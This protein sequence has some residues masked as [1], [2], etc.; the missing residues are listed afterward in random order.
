[1]QIFDATPLLPEHHNQWQQIQQ[2]ILKKRLSQ[3]LLLIG[4]TD[5]SLPQFVKKLISLSFCVANT[6]EPCMKCHHCRMIHKAEHPDVHWIKPDKP[7]NGLKIEQIRQLQGLAYQTPQC[8]ASQFFVLEAAE[9]M[10]PSVANALLKILEEPSEHSF[11][12]LVAEHLSS[13]LPTVISRCHILRFHKNIKNNELLQLA[14]HLFAL[15]SEP[16]SSLIVSVLDDLIELLIGKTIPTLI[17]IRWKDH[18]FK[19]LLELL[20]L[21]FSQLIYLLIQNQ[22]AT[23]TYDKYLNQLL[24]LVNLHRMFLQLS[25]ITSLLQ[26]ISHNVN[27]NQSLAIEDLCIHLID[28]R[29]NKKDES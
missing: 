24:P 14:N 23:G 27:I 8:A 26:K 16:E 3:A 10:N 11:F 20:S 6:S 19:D 12:V 5:C 13:L 22:K 15:N 1:M 4:S 29:R 28:M 18:E 7:G 21:V 25:K 17:A 9:R 2:A